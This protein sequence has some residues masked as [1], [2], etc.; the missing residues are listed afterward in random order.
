MMVGLE[1][2]LYTDV[3]LKTYRLN[4]LILEFMLH[5]LLRFM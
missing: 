5:L 3:Q 4:V 1:N 2:E